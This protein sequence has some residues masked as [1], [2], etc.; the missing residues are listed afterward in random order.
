MGKNHVRRSGA[1]H[2]KSA[3]V[4]ERIAEHRHRPRR[5]LQTKE[6]YRKIRPQGPETQHAQPEHQIRHHE[7]H[8]SEDTG[9]EG[10]TEKTVSIILE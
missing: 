8:T 5:I 2:W 4:G 9:A 6:T 10:P 7:W 3:A 1:G